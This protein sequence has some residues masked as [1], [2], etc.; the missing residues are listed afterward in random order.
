MGYKMT[1]IL[2]LAANPSDTSNR[3]LGQ[4]IRAI[5]EKI[6]R[7][8]FRD[9]FDIEKHWAVRISELQ[10][11]LLRHKPDIVHFSGHGSRSSGIILQ[12]ESDR[13]HP[14][15]I[16]ALG[17]LFSILKDNIRCVVLNSCYT[18][19]Q[20][21]A[22]ANHIECVVG[23]SKAIT[24]SAAISFAAS[25]Y[26]A[27]GFGRSVKTAFDL[28]CNEL[29]LHGFGEED[30]PKLLALN[31][32]PDT[33]FFSIS[34]KLIRDLVKGNELKRLKIAKELATTSQMHLANLLIVRSTADPD[35]TVRYWLNR[36]LG[37]VGSAEAII[38]LRRNMD[39]PDP[40]GSLGASDA[41]EE[42]GVEI[43]P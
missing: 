42:L 33:F 10:G 26:Q 11:F 4:E 21:E 13:S 25:F 34:D 35:P 3:R 27:L 12:N 9:R 16:A 29:D 22:I 24:D 31:A 15:P 17:R 39:D 37:K 43:D 2:F 20:A 8:E 41:L 32:D 23:M 40:F 14:V 6:G 19:E 30:T 5:D 18:E 28:A 36:A 1:R 38:A 7:S